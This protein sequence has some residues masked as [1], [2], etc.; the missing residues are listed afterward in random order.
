MFF[1]DTGEFGWSGVVQSPARDA[2]WIRWPVGD[3][4][5]AQPDPVARAG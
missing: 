4:R 2:R 1:A 5:A 3:C